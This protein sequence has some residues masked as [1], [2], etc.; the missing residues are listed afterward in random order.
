MKVVLNI[1]SIAV[2]VAVA[3]VVVEFV[4]ASVVAV[5]WRDM[6]EYQN[7]NPQRE[8]HVFDVW[9]VSWRQ[10]A[11]GMWEVM[12]YFLQ[13][14]VNPCNSLVAIGSYLTAP[15]GEAIDYYKVE[16]GYLQFPEFVADGEL[17]VDRENLAN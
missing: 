7:Q 16:R 6:I 10:Y 14:M 3:F 2:L 11:L 9:L 4:V 5:V 15:N 13:A 8:F 17:I 12:A 1:D